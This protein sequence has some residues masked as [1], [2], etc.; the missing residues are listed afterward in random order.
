[1]ERLLFMA[2]VRSADTLADTMSARRPPVTS[3]TI[4]LDELSPGLHGEVVGLAGGDPDPVGR[5]LADLGFLAGTHVQALRRAPM[6]DPTVYQL[7]NYQMCLR[8]REAH[9]IL[10]SVEGTDRVLP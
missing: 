2:A 3:H 7:R 9:R 8:A 1:M 10:V 4:P 6:G 5:R